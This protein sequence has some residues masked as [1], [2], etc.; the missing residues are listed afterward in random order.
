MYWFFFFPSYP[1]PSPSLNV[2]TIFDCADDEAT[3]DESEVSS[4]DVAVLAQ[5][6]SAD[7]DAGRMQ[8]DKSL[9]E[10]NAAHTPSSPATS[11]AEED[12]DDEATRD[13][14]EVSSSDVAVL[15]QKP[16]AD[17]QR[18]SKKRKAG[19]LSSMSS[20]K[21]RGG[22][23][24]QRQK[25][26]DHYVEQRDGMER[27]C[28]RPTST[29]GIAVAEKAVSLL[30]EDQRFTDR[31]FCVGDAMNAT[32]GK[33]MMTRAN[34]GTLATDSLRIHGLS[35][36]SVYKRN[37]FNVRTLFAAI[38]K[39][40]KKNAITFHPRLQWVMKEPAGVFLFEFFWQIGG[41]GPG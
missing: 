10:S 39:R 9:D 17:A 40:R 32:S 30:P 12:S 8:V 2:E 11:E 15:A 21:G 26:S 36:A 16:S 18:P 23:Y 6:P 13:E 7:V 3:R 41:G 34:T 22:A 25:V 24:V 20:G 14:S 29:F 31:Y 33:Q 5:K 38:K 4:S 35:V 1:S 27:K 19:Y 37:G 28:H